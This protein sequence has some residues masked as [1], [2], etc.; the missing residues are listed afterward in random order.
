MLGPELVI[1]WNAVLLKKRIMIV[2][3]ECVEVMFCAFPF[4]IT[5]DCKH[6]RVVASVSLLLP[7]LLFVCRKCF[8]A[9][10]SCKSV[11]TT[12]LAQKRL[13]NSAPYREK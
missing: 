10:S 1:L 12:L 11:A 5:I 13:F 7:R 8:Q 2:S 6:A 9:T 3:G 4:L